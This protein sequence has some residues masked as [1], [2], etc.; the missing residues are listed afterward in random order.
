MQT[1]SDELLKLMGRHYDTAFFEE[2]IACVRR[3]MEAP[4]KP[5]VFFGIDLMVGLPGETPELFE[6]SKAFI[7]RIHP[8]FIHVFPYSRRPGTPAASM[9]GQVDELEKKRR[10]AVLEELSSR[11]HAEFI[12]ANRGVRET[13]LFESACKQGLMEGYTGNY[14][15][16]SRPYD[17]GLVNTLVDV[18][19]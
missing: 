13:V 3:A 17:P 5:L 14:I 1:G 2:K 11:L 8:A 18:T 6:Q 15:R 9:P 7:E 12:E 4:G 19:I 10:V 16:I